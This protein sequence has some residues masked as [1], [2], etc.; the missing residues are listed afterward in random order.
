MDVSIVVVT[1]RCREDARECLRSLYQ[2]IQGVTFEVIVLDNASGD[3]TI[4]M[5]RAEFPDARLVELE[6]NIGF[7]RG[8][9]RAAAMAQGENILLLNPDAVVHPGAGEQL[10]IFARTH[11]EHGLYAGRNLNSDGTV[12]TSSVRGR[13]SLW[14]LFCFATMLSTVF[15]RTRLFDPESLGRWPRDT[16]REVGSAI[17]SFLLVP[18]AVWQALGGFDTRFFMYGEDVDL[19]LRA[20]AAGWRPVFVPDAVVTHKRGSSSD[21]QLERMALVYQGKAT[22][23]RKH[24]PA[25][26]RQL[27]LA[28][29]WLGVG[30]RASLA[31]ISRRDPETEGGLWRGVWRARRIWIQGYPPFTERS[32]EGSL[33]AVSTS[34]GA[35]LGRA[36]FADGS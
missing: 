13:P 1:Y 15:P 30:L 3:G 2:Q 7:A 18:R 24:W 31:K 36:G 34:D 20:A 22:L 9:N 10:V 6:E 16:V 23:L 21:S 28:L 5:V 29:L 11:P 19:S 4:E 27:G 14:G 32:A 26:K 8:V 33:A 12:F 35:V 25:G 17:G